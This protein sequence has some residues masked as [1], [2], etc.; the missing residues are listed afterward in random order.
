[1]LICRAI[2]PLAIAV[3]L[4]RASVTPGRPKSMFS[5]VIATHDS[6]RALV[7]TLAALVP[8]ATAG[9]VREV[10]VADGGSHD[11]TEEVAD[12][13]GCRFLVSTEPLGARLKTAAGQAR[14]DWLMFLDAGAVPGATW[15][16]ETIAFAEKTGADERAAVFAGEAGF[17]A[18]LRRAF[19]LP[20]A[21]QGLI[22][23]KS[24]Y[25]ALGGHRADSAAPEQEPAAPD[26]AAA[27]R[28]VAHAASSSPIFD[29]VNQLIDTVICPLDRPVTHDDCLGRPR[30][31][32]RG[33]AA[34]QPLLHA[35]ARAAAGKPGAH[36]VLAHRGA[37]ALRAG[38]SR[39][40]H[41]DRAR[42]RPRSRPRLSQP[43][44]SALRRS[45]PDQE[46]ANAG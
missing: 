16:D 4:A 19:L 11:K 27:P 32:H 7:P 18:S 46:D 24:F 33:G 30:N 13:A 43:H 31:P 40:D 42:R 15:I 1:M 44:F 41:R 9:I 26:R 34:L 23:R 3:F 36:A 21:Q 22:L 20:A 12:I 10:I 29:S 8:G 28:H 25:D 5:I 35:P 37:R 39:A 6:E 17:A 2:H 38:A 14:G 45:G